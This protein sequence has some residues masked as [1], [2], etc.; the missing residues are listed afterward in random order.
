MAQNGTTRRGLLKGVA[1]GTAG[2]VGIIMGVKPAE[3]KLPSWTYKA[4]VVVMGL[5]GAGCATA[6]TAARAGAS[7]IVIE[8]QP[9]ATCRPN[10]RMSGGYF[11]SA[12]KATY[13][14]AALKEYAKAMFSG[15]NIP[16]KTEGE[17]SEVSDGLAE[18]WA[19]YLPGLKEWMQELDPDFRINMGRAHAGGTK[20]QAAFPDFP[21]AKESGYQV[22]M[23]TYRKRAA[24]NVSSY[25]KPKLERTNG[26]AFWTCL[27]VGMSKLPNIKV[28]FETR[29]RHLVKNDRGEVIGLTA[30]M[31]GKPISIHASQ[32][33]VI[34][35][36]GY[37]YSPTMRKAFL[38][39]EEE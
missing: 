31:K 20:S 19:E 9:E 18:A 29:G 15:E 7:V 10:T 23:A 35:S 13:S 25:N 36:G 17:Q 37:E 33:V 24:G 16:W 8:R 21:G 2:S 34:C 3:A 22:C 11:H 32:G 14:K 27:R 26:E 39:G 38:E 1:A 30:E 6:I 12:D 4:D 28:L 5:G